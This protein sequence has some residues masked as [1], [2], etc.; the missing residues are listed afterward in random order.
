MCVC[1]CACVCADLRVGGGIPAA[2]GEVWWVVTGE[3]ANHW[4]KAQQV[5]GPL[6]SWTG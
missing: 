4:R 5:N 1:V 2:G 3:M 6:A